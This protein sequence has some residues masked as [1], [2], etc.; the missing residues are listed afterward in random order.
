MSPTGPRKTRPDDRLSGVI[1]RCKERIASR[2]FKAFQ[3]TKR[4]G[5]GLGLGR[6]EALENKSRAT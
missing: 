1:R 4:D 6:M 3:S 2:L 5:M